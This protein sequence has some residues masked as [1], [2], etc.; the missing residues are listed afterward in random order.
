M[1]DE[2]PVKA[3]LEG[4]RVAEAL[5]TLDVKAISL[6]NHSGNTVAEAWEMLD[7][8]LTDDTPVEEILKGN[9]VA[10]ALGTLDINA[11][12]PPCPQDQPV[13]AAP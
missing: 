10:E 7:N 12:I 13:H 11:I 3:I 6:G 9:S 2:G 8:G 4:N 1:K 5:G